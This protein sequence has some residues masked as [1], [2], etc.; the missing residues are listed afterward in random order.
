MKKLF[1]IIALI[2][3][4]FGC[5]ADEYRYRYRDNDDYYQNP[6]FWRQ[7][8]RRLLRQYHRID[9][10]LEHGRLNRH[11]AHKLFRH[12]NRLENR[13]EELRCENGFVDPY[14]RQNILRYLN[15]NEQRINKYL[16]H[17]HDKFRHHNR[18]ANPYN[19]HAYFPNHGIQWSLGNTR[20]GFYFGY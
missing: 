16:H 11:Q 15:R 6:Q 4:T 3:V 20:G 19:T 13:I 5:S 7:V 8:D 18:Y 12:I 1:F 9:E 17:R 14:Q 2:G 10:S